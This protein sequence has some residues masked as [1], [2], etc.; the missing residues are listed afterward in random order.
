MFFLFPFYY[1][2]I[3]VI[4]IGLDHWLGEPSRWHPLRGFGSLVTAVERW[5]WRG[6]VGARKQR[7][8]GLVAFLVATS[9][10]TLTVV[11][12]Q[13]LMYPLPVI[14]FLVSVIIVY[15]CIAAR[16]LR[17]HAQA[18][19]QP[20][21]ANNLEL[22]RNKLSCIV[23]RDTDQLSEPE[24]AAA[25]C[26]SVLENGSDG[27]FAAIAWFLIAG[28]PGVVLYRAVNTLDAMWG[29]KNQRYNDF[30]W[31]A[32]KADDVMNWLPARLVA[33]SYALMGN[34]QSAINCWS[35][36]ASQ[37]KSPNAGP[38]MAAGAG[39][40][41]ICL[42]GDARYHGERQAR[43]QLGCG[44]APGVDD[45]ARALALITRVLILWVA[46]LLLLAVVIQR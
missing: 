40:L 9:V 25:V 2:S 22:A 5:F 10:V 21:L 36:Q 37:W 17:E 8:A 28:L 35:Q 14:D 39:S 32:A 20:L 1:C 15:A 4:A 27:V 16:S 41:K 29:Y 18:I 42:G 23:S 12:L 26:E 30:G 31:A 33:L 34:F 7:L 38:V 11:V 19:V 44:N 45:I 24:I 46:V 3:L 6:H 13:W 43:P